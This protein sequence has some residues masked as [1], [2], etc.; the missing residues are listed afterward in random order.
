[1]GPERIVVSSYTLSG[2]F[3][4]STSLYSC[5]SNSGN[6]AILTD[7]YWIHTCCQRQEDIESEGDEDEASKGEK[8][9]VGSRTERPHQ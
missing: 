9:T 4:E 6:Y 3:K 5:I 2:E 8:Q 1:M 7:G